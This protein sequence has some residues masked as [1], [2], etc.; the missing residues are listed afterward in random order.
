MT[1]LRVDTIRSRDGNTGPIFEGNLSFSSTAHIVLPKGTTAERPVGISTGSM[2][3]NTDTSVVEYWNGTS[4]VEVSSYD[5]GVRGVFGGG[6]ST[7]V[8]D[9]ISIGSLG[10]TTDFGDLTTVRNSLTSCSSSTRGVFG[11]GGPFLN[12][13]DYITIA[14]TGNAIDFGDLTVGRS[15][16]LAA[17][18]SST[19]GVFGG[20]NTP[21]S[22]NVID[23]ITIASTG[24][25]TDFG[26]LTVARYNLGACSSSTR[27]VFGG[28]EPASN[29][30]DYITIA[31]TGNATDFGDLSVAR[32]TPA[33]CSSSTRGVFGG[34]GSSPTP[35]FTGLN[36]IDYITISSTGN[37]TDFGDLTIARFQLASCSS[38]TRGVFGG[39]YTPAPAVTNTIDYV[40]IASIGNAAD[41]GDLTTTRG[42]LAACSNAHGGLS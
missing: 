18:S 11:G 13:I 24:N 20:G 36:T 35:A 38:T 3:Y 25:A 32:L 31:S 30:I 6:S 26:D 41:F 7:N 28:S 22:S 4:W 17:C 1:N 33:A 42:T 16:G 23:Y 27:G 29:V 8:I 40:T 21:V 37:A 12:V 10:N 2:R 5:A 19:R 14:T 15:N 9:Y 39:G 34:G